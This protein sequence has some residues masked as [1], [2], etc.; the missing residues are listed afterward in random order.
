[1]KVGMYYNNRDVRIEEMPVPDIGDKDLLVK[2]MACGIC[3][4]DVMEW[5][6][7]KRAP[8]VLGHELTGKVVKVGKDIKKYK[9]GDRVVSTHH[10]PW[11]ECYYCLTNHETA[12]ETFHTKNN[13]HPGGFA[14]YL[15]ISGKSLDTGTFILPDEISY[16]QGTFIEPLATVV[17]GLRMADLHPGNSVL[18][19]GCG[20][21]GML[22]I[23]L[24]KA[25]G[26]GRVIATDISDYRLDMAKKFGAEYVFNAKEDL[27]MQ[28]KKVNAGRLVDKVVL[29]TGVLSAV[30]QALLSVDRGGTILFF[31]VPKPGETVAMD[32]NS[33]WR[34]DINFKTSYGASPLDNMQAL[35]LIRAGNVNVMD[36]ITHR[37]SIDE[38]GEGFKLAS[39]GKECLKV[40]I[41]PNKNE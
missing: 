16:E 2:V 12:C 29:C 32:F 39:E 35:E 13:F 25:L 33:Y 38:I 34:N 3:G 20:I 26:A 4:S 41:T 10:V 23:K 27:P 1:M 36:M 19:L 9:I 37:L 8:L 24:A 5:Y 30:G 31:A 6:R 17:R 28:I 21:A 40:I 15:K 7:I 11:G 18:I 14:E 22:N